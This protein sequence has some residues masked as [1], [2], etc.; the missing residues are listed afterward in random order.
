MLL[1]PVEWNRLAQLVARAPDETSHLRFVVQRP[2]GRICRDLRLRALDLAFRASNRRTARYDGRRT[3][4][5]ADRNPLVVREQW[6]VGTKHATHV[7]RVIYRGVEV[8][9]VAHLGW[10]QQLGVPHGDE[11]IL[12]QPR[13][14]GW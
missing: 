4:V 1:G 8:G 11:N 9:V 6:I 12:S 13:P 2:A 10:N 14:V 5:I 3:S 7:G